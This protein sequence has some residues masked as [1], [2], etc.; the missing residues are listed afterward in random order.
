MI[1]I[2]FFSVWESM[3]DGQGDVQDERQQVLQ[4]EQYKQQNPLFRDDVTG[5]EEVTD[6]GSTDQYVNDQHNNYLHEG[7]STNYNYAYIN[8]PDDL[9]NQEYLEQNTN[10]LTGSMVSYMMPDGSPVKDKT[11]NTYPQ[12][13]DREDPHDYGKQTN[14]DHAAAVRFDPNHG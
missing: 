7:S 11:L 4:R 6:L 13:D 2:D 9:D 3:M 5:N 8:K 14:S 10:Y 12:D 1:F